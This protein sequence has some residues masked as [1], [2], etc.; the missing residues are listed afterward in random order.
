MESDSCQFTLGNWATASIP[1]TGLTLWWKL[2]RKMWQIMIL[3]PLDFMSKKLKTIEPWYSL[4]KH[5]WHLGVFGP[6]EY[7][8]K[9]LPITRIGRALFGKKHRPQRQLDNGNGQHTLSPGDWVEV[10][11]LD[12][13]F[14]TLNAEGKLGGL[15]FT[16]EM[17][18]YCGQRFRVHKKVERIILESTGS[19]RKI[20]TP[21]VI[22]EGVFCDGE[23][24]GSCDRTCFC[25]W[26]TS[27]LKKV[28]S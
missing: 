23:A 8:S 9:I 12:E 6:S 24:H 11:P 1:D 18:K 27:W 2:R 5:M 26:R 4:K 13:I 25:F 21:T 3:T 22:L 19:I 14:A 28:S 10:K 15:A 7:L 20:R 17:I 16:K